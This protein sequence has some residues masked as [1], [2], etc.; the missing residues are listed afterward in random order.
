MIRVLKCCS[1]MR[2]FFHFSSLSPV[3]FIFLCYFCSFLFWP[4]RRFVVYFSVHLILNITISHSVFTIHQPVLFS[5]VPSL[6]H[7][8]RV[9]FYI[10]TTHT[11][12]HVSILILHRLQQFL[13]PLSSSILFAYYIRGEGKNEFVAFIVQF[14]SKMIFYFLFCFIT[15]SRYNNFFFK[16]FHS[17]SSW[18]L[19][20]A[21]FFYF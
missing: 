2:S 21:L 15:V 9:F 19:V 12:T 7:I 11:N 10:I 8:L 18:I 17:L 14:G 16:Y 1:E 6:E 20:Y 3:F 13:F 4:K 5:L